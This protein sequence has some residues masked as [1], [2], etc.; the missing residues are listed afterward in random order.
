MKTFVTAFA[1]TALAAGFATASLAQDSVADGEFEGETYTGTID[2]DILLGNDV[3]TD[4]GDYLGKIVSID[5]GEDG[6]ANRF[7]VLND[8]GE[9]LEVDVASAVQTSVVPTTT[10][11]E[12]FD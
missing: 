9:E 2:A 12:L 11:E 10:S 8:I 1:A 5:E 3:W 6:L 7:L 4:E